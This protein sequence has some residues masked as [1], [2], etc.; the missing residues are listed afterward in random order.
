V[1]GDA[2]QDATGPGDA[3]R[4]AAGPGDAVRRGWAF[5]RHRAVLLRRSPGP[6]L[7]YPVMAVAL[8]VFVEPL[9]H[10]V[11]EPH[12]PGPPHPPGLRAAAGMVVFCT[13]L[14]TGVVGSALVD[15][16]GWHTAERLATTPA[17]PLERLVGGALPLLGVLL[18]QQAAVLATAALLLPGSPA[19]AAW[20]AWPGLVGAGL[21]WSV[22]VLGLGSLLGAATARPGQL[23]AVKDLVALTV[24][25]TGGAIVPPA[26]LPTWVRPVTGWSPASW[27]VRACL[28]GPGTG[29]REL[30]LVGTG[31]AA[32]VLAAAV[33][34]RR[35]PA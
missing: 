16:R 12:P 25:G 5:A 18:C 13:L 6:V 34:P 10:L 35:G 9:M 19:W 2:V 29:G 28:G 23:A 26:A 7:V 3:V 1:P 21:A 30:L 20:P 11:P 24:A 8:T 4:D 32:F 22:C 15:E 17:R 14:M 33:L 27:A 31:A